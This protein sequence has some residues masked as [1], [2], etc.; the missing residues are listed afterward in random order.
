MAVEKLPT[1]RLAMFALGQFGWSLGSWSVGN[2]INFFFMPP[3]QSGAA[4][5]FPVFIFQGAVLGI[6]T[7][8]GLI[9]WGGRLWDA[10]TDPWIANMSDR[11]KS[12]F[13][14]RR[15]FLAISA[16][17]TAVFAFLVFVPLAN[18]GSAAGQTVNAVW[19]A[20]TMTLYYLFITMYCTPYN[21]LISE[22]G[23]TPNERLGIATAISITWALGF[24][25]GNQ[26][27]ALT[28]LFQG[29]FGVDYTR[30]FQI[31]LGVFEL[32][33]AVF[34]LLP[35]FFVPERRYAETHASD[36][37]MFQAV[38]STFKNRNFL[39]F[40]LSDLPYWIALNFIQMGI[41]YYVIT[42]LG[43]DTSLPSFLLLVMFILSFVFYIPINLVAKKV[44]KKPVLSLAFIVF[45]AVFLLAFFFG[46][47]PLP[48]AFQAWMVIVI[49]S[50][51]IAIFGILPN[52]IVADIAESHGIETGDY[53]AGIFFGARTFMMKM[54]IAVANLLFPSL[55]LI[56]KSVDNPWGLRIS[57]L[58]AVGF[59]LLGLFFF[60]RYDEKAILKTLATKEQLSAEEKREAGL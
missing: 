6:A 15:L 31:T 32:V 7:V 20:V 10:V 16:I 36:E 23:H 8:I 52:A 17:P 51:P 35:V 24:A 28:P 57:A 54:G 55:L 12:K 50:L 37:G 11:N 25:I 29:M 18:G 38:K 3:E 58:A 34:M 47:M 1:W 14:R 5:L 48:A 42:L 40:V 22:L 46:W 26:A 39:R 41:T 45:A 30:G 19:L 60:R 44:G 43:L 53:K 9:N 13:G 33:A 2:A 59:C 56:G 49:A 4:P 21:S 27:Y